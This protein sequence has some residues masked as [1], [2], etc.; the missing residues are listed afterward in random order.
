MGEWMTA[1]EAA[2]YL[3]VSR[4]TIYRWASAG[5]LPHYQVGQSDWRFR[6]EDLDAAYRQ[7]R[8]GDPAPPEAGHPSTA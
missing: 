6:P 1:G 4:P 8:Q 3:K 5:L 7:V 2:A